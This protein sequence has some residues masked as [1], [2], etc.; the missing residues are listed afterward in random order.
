[1]CYYTVWYPIGWT[2]KCCSSDENKYCSVKFDKIVI[3]ARTCNNITGQ[4]EEFESMTGIPIEL[5]C[6]LLQTAMFGANTGVDYFRIIF[7]QIVESMTDYTLILCMAGIFTSDVNYTRWNGHRTP[8][9]EKH[10]Q[11]GVNEIALVSK[12]QR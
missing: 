7:L 1:M 10:M 8:C 5:L 12:G 2:I 3:H 9:G 6:Y 11:S 4:R